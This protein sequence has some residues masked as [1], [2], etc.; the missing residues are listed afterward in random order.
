LHDVAKTGLAKGGG[1]DGAHGDDRG[2]A[3]YVGKRAKHL[4][5]FA[6][7]P[8]EKIADGGRAEEQN[9]L[10]PAGKELRLPFAFRFRGERAIGDDF[11][12]VR[13]ETAERVWKL[14]AG[15]VA[16][17]EK[18]AFAGELGGK[19]LCQSQ[20]LVLCSDL[21]H[22]QTGAASRFGGDRTYGCDA[23]SSK[24]IH[25]VDAKR[26]RAF[27]QGAHGVCAGEQ[28]PVER[29]ESAK[30]LVQRAKIIWGVKRDHG[31]EHGLGAAS[32]EFANE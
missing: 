30:R 4:A 2:F 3:G 6:F 7:V 22:G 29:T 26:L 25:N 9:S 23:E 14:R 16:A 11:S 12:D 1:G 27:H 17:R 31:L 8:I 13:A 5:P 32:L 15:Q 19:F 21:T 28:E 20:A 18:D 24:G 10:Q